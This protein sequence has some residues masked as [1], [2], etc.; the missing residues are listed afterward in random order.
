VVQQAA[1]SRNDVRLMREALAVLQEARDIYRDR[2][3]SESGH[4]MVANN[5]GL[6]QC[7]LRMFDPGITNLQIAIEYF[8]RTGQFERAAA[9]QQALGDF[10]RVSARG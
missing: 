6:V 9:T 2:L 7:Q 10:R 5:L 8:E 1:E 4:A 3:Q